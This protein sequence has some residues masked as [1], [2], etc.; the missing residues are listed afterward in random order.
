LGA[1]I[2]NGFAASL[3]LFD[4]CLLNGLALKKD[5]AKEKEGNQQKGDKSNK[6]RE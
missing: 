5:R 1:V 4:I 2:S 6:V 3:K